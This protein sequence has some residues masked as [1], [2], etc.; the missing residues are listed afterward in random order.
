MAG[1]APPGLA[2]LAPSQ[3]LGAPPGPW[4]W[5]LRPIWPPDPQLALSLPGRRAD[6][7]HGRTFF[8]GKHQGGPISH[9]RLPAP[10]PQLQGPSNLRSQGQRPHAQPLNLSSLPSHSP[11]WRPLLRPHQ[12]PLTQFIGIYPVAPAT[13]SSSFPSLPQMP[14]SPPNWQGWSTATGSGKPSDLSS[15]PSPP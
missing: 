1:Q 10:H 9:L 13:H 8:Q 7:S 11:F 5:R 4:E 12:M 3:P 6:G 14:P 2:T 15:A